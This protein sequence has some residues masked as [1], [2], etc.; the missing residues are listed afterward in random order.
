MVKKTAQQAGSSASKEIVKPKGAI[1]AIISFSLT[2][3]EKELL[4]VWGLEKLEK[5]SRLPLDTNVIKQ[6]AS[7]FNKD[8]HT[9]CVNG[10][11]L[12]LTIAA[13]E[14]VFELPNA[15]DP[16]TC[17]SEAITAF[18]EESPEQWKKR[19]AAGQGI[20]VD[21]LPNHK[22]YSYSVIMVD[23]AH[24]RTVSIDVL[25]GLV[26]DIACFRPDIK[27]LFSSATLDANK[28][29]D[30]F[31]GAPIFNILGRRYLVDILYTKALEADYVEA[32]IVTVLQIHVTHQSGDIL[33]FLFG[34][35][36][37]E[38]VEEI[39]KAQI[40]GLGSQVA[41]MIICPIYASLPSD[42]Q[43]KVF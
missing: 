7:S 14:H 31:D 8:T 9:T 6:A 39:L 30:Y 38:A 33:V 21:K 20:S 42:L 5:A 1:K 16:K 25:F 15:T 36:E 35:H 27:L 28:F 18:L 23:E 26:K 11:T 13:I 29:P 24:E 43:A 3:T 32:A 17:T 22:A 12:Q 4:K 37:I 40:R 41:E 10:R 19:K 2:P 34:K